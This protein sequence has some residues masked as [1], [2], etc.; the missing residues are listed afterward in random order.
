MVTIIRARV[1]HFWPTLPEVEI[2][3]QY[4]SC[5][6]QLHR[7]DRARNIPHQRLGHEQVYMLTH[8][9]KSDHAKPIPIP[10]SH[11]LQNLK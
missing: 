8:H 5:E 3:R 11:L 4:S 9:N 6:P 7:T 10:I 1:P 2:L